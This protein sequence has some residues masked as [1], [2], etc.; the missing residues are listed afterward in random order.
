[1]KLSLFARGASF[2]SATKIDKIHLPV[3]R[4]F[5]S[6]VSGSVGPYVGQRNCGSTIFREILFSGL[7]DFRP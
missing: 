6:L 4:L 3:D 7:K 1:M 2:Y 5:L